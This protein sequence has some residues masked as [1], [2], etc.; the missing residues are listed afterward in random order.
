VDLEERLRDAVR[1]ATSPVPAAVAA[2]WASVGL[3]A[4]PFLARS[5]TR[6]RHALRIGA[7]VVALGLAARILA[8]ATEDAPEY[9]KYVDEV[10]A[11]PEELREKHLQVHGCVVD[12]SF[13]RARGAPDRYRF[14]L[15]TARHDRPRLAEGVLRVAYDGELPPTFGERRE[16]VVKG[17]LGPNGTLVAIRD[18]LMFKCPS[19]Y[20][21]TEPYPFGLMPCPP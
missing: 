18:G 3:L 8:N 15:A 12:G 6:L 2:A 17:Q 4:A 5:R 7:T 16:V 13:E 20:D 11:H 19:K 9:Y 1:L 10:L 21:S 14:S